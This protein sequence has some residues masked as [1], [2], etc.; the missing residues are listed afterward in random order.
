MQ[1]NEQFAD[2]LAQHR[3]LPKVTQ[4]TYDKI[5]LEKASVLRRSEVGKV[6]IVP[7][8]LAYVTPQHLETF[9][10]ACRNEGESIPDKKLMRLLRYCS[11]DLRPIILNELTDPN[12]YDVLVMR[13]GWGDSGVKE[14]LD[15]IYQDRLAVY[16]A[17]VEESLKQGPSS[18][19]ELL[20]LAGV[21]MR[22]SDGP[23][24]RQRLSYL[25]QEVVRKTRSLGIG[26]S[27]TDPRYAEL[28]M[29]SF[30]VALSKLPRVEATSI[31]KSYLRQTKFV[32]FF[33]DRERDLSHVVALLKDGDR[34]LAEEVFSV[35]AGLPTSSESSEI[36][37]GE[38]ADQRDQ[39][40]RRY[41]N[42]NSAAC[43]EAIS[44][45][46][47]IESIPLLLE[48]LD[49]DNDQLRAFIVWR[50]TSLGYEWT[51]EQLAGLRQD[52]F[53][54]VRMNALF[55]FNRDDL[56]LFNEDENPLVQI[57]ARILI[58]AETL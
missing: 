30:F 28:I 10:T 24:G 45:Y 35:L 37:A 15:S 54:K 5:I 46:L 50:V 6:I 38:S 41:R 57:I 12:S 43:L 17:G 20:Q 11:P 39:R 47:N 19:S 55:A 27:L 16:S 53:W 33:G 7:E 44:A 2:P 36:N 32:D 22:L 3:P 49:S 31:L 34:E 8:I 25:L 51:D 58:D 52:S 1:M 29:R 21:L 14:E 23:E 4:E 18:L 13:A 56:A 40:L 26:P 42:R 48:H 9:L